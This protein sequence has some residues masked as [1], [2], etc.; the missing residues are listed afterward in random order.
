LSSRALIGSF[1]Q[2]VKFKN[3][4]LLF[5]V[6]AVMTFLGTYSIQSADAPAISLA[7][8]GVSGQVGTGAEP[9]RVKRLEITKPGVY[10]N[11]LVDGE[12]GDINLVKIQ[13]NDVVLRHCEIRNSTRNG[14]SVY[15]KNVVI[16][17]CRIHHLLSGTF[18]DQHDAHGITGAPTK[19]VIRNCEIYLVSGD[20]V[21][22]DPGRALWDDVLIE[23]CTFWTGPLPEKAGGFQAGERPGENALDTK[24]LAT[25]PRSKI[26]VRNCL[27]YGWKQPGQ[28]DN[29]AAL[30]L[31]D[32]V[33]VLVEGCVLR[34]N[35]IC[36]RLRGDGGTG[37]GGALVTVR[38]CAVYDSAV[39]VR[40]ENAIK[41]LK[42]YRLGIGSGI[43]NKMI[44]AGG[45]YG[46]GF[47]NEGEHPAPPLASGGAK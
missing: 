10:E 36:F 37:R 42:L 40:A 31:K 26:T 38:D 25:N 34:D 21:Q 6:P 8:V 44:K 12:W 5:L 20:S 23:N 33:E 32:N 16:D 29:L 18:K 11:Y 39:A 22:F 7:K 14:V 17:S 13:T 24:Q 45:G 19:L 9:K 3:S 47:I 4:K 43:A 1:A 46:T 30:N 28:I 15:A 27:M 41:D 35:E 2:T